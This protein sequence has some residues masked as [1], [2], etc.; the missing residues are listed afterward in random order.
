MLLI[1]HR[2]LGISKTS[3]KS[4]L[5]VATMKQDVRYLVNKCKKCQ[6][7][8]NLIHRPAEPL[9]VMLSPCPFSQWGMDI[10][11]PFPLAPGQ[12]KF[13][14]VAIEYFTKWVKAEPLARITEGEVMN[15]IWKNIICRFELP[16]ELISDNG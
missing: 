14:L 1:Q 6:K 2:D 10:V 4:W 13:L 9:N 11:E 16:R 15:F 12:K 8:A 7:Y 5:L 3:A